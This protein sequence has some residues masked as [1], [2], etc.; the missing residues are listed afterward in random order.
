MNKLLLG[1]KLAKKFPNTK[2]GVD[3]ILVKRSDEDYELISWNVPG[4]VQPTLEEIDAYY[5]DAI[6]EAARP[7]PEAAITR[8]PIN[9]ALLKVIAEVTNTPYAQIVSKLRTYLANGG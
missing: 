8:N 6:I 1:E 7:G 2:P 4:V 5:P 3:W 9:N